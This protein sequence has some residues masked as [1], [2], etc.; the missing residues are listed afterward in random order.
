MVFSECVHHGW[1]GWWSELSCERQTD[2]EAA[3]LLT[4]QVPWLDSNSWRLA[5]QQMG[6]SLPGKCKVTDLGGYRGWQGG[7]GLRD[8]RGKVSRNKICSENGVES[9]SLHFPSHLKC[10]F[11]MMC[12]ERRLS[13]KITLKTK[14][15][16]NFLFQIFTAEFSGGAQ[17]G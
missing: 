9:L 5:A 7:L 11:T 14:K 3:M 15:S 16:E 6:K 12:A 2:F 10:D 13:K 17:M 1:Y 8:S 4:S